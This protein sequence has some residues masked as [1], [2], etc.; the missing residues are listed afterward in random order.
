MV[1]KMIRQLRFNNYCI[2]LISCML[3]ISCAKGDM[4]DDNDDGSSNGHSEMRS[5]EAIF[6]DFAYENEYESEPILPISIK[7]TIR[8]N[9]LVFPSYD[10][11][12]EALDSIATK[13]DE[14]IIAWSRSIGF[15]SLTTIYNEVM[16]NVDSTNESHYIASYSDIID[17]NGNIPS[18]K[19]YN[20]V[21]S[22]F[23]NRDGYLYIGDT[24]GTFPNGNS[25][26]VINGNKA[27]LDLAIANETTDSLN[28]IY[29]FPSTVRGIVMNQCAESNWDSGWIEERDSDRAILGRFEFVSITSNRS[30]GNRDY[31]IFAKISSKSYKKGLFGKY[32]K[33]Y[34]TDHYHYWDFETY[35]YNPKAGGRT[36]WFGNRRGKKRFHSKWKINIFRIK[37][38]TE[39]ERQAFGIGLQAV[40]KNPKNHYGTWVSHRGMG[41]DRISFSCND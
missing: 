39:A 2:L 10:A 17:F 1:N 41:G 30:N 26:W 13:S 23:L 16:A 20:S 27:S 37:D 33:R 34:K 8:D 22:S 4:R 11:F 31:E 32:G 29:Y 18:I 36:Q 9:S 15:N 3:F 12:Y 28:G 40:Y 19:K 6:D 24:I 35:H 5:S 21:V 38:I 7:V 25:V 14:S